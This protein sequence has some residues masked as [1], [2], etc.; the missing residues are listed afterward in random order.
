[1]F[2]ALNINLSL[3]FTCKQIIALFIKMIKKKYITEYFMIVSK[4]L[5]E[6]IANN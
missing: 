5:E 4:L 3:Y 2:L 1:M 6:T